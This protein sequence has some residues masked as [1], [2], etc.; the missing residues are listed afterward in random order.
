MKVRGKTDV[1]TNSSS[2]VFIVRTDVKPSRLRHLL[3]QMKTEETMFS[4]EG[5]LIECFNNE[6][7][8]NDYPWDWDDPEQEHYSEKYLHKPF[9]FMPQ[10][11]VAVHIDYG[12]G[13]IIGWLKANYEVLGEV[14]DRGEGERI[15]N[16]WLEEYWRGRKAYWDEKLQSIDSDEALKEIWPQFER[17]QECINYHVKS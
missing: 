4:G 16:G 15:F 12:L 2:E 9:R 3:E 1:I 14:D 17:E 11:Y 7:E 5:G 10:D 8:V 6:T 13:D